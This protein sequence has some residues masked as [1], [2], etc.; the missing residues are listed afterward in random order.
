M[1]ET[2]KIETPETDRVEV[3]QDIKKE[4]KLLGSQ[5]KIKGLTMFEYNPKD[6]TLEPAKFEE[7]NAE[8]QG[9]VIVVRNKLIYKDGC[10]YIQALNKRVA[11]KKLVKAKLIKIK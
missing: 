8:L 2:S 9:K 10:S 11:F 7:V 4:V 1:K 6:Q 5:R 3:V